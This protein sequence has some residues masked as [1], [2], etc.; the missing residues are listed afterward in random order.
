M[1]EIKTKYFLSI[2]PNKECVYNEYLPES[3]KMTA[4]R[5]IYDVIDV[6]AGVIRFN[7]MLDVLRC[8]DNAYDTFMKGDTH[9]THY[10]AFL[11]F[12]KLMELNG[13]APLPDEAMQFID[14]ECSGDLASK[15]G[16]RTRTR[17]AKVKDKNFTRIDDNGVKNIGQRIIFENADKNLPTLVLFRDSFAVFQLDMFASLF[18]RVVCL[19]QPNI[20]YGIVRREKPD[21]VMSQHVERFFVRCPDDRFGP[22]NVE[23]EQQKRGES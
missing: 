11:A 10:G 8:K 17:I 15:V 22:S 7:Y 16:E 1:S 5:T 19:W 20:D 9:W 13:I 4:K 14:K 12:N 2:I 3:V 23:Y 21:F 18:S 6:A